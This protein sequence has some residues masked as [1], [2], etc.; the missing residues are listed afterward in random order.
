MRFLSSSVLAGRHVVALK[1]K[2]G[3]PQFPAGHDCTRS[4]HVERAATLGAA[5]AV[6]CGT[7]SS[8]PAFLSGNPGRVIGSVYVC[9]EHLN[10]QLGCVSGRAYEMRDR[11]VC[12]T[13]ID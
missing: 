11:L 6:V 12:A 9:A 1:N 4:T 13:V 3:Y 2:L 8:E 7:T 10:Y 5:A